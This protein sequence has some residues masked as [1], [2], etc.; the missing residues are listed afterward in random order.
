MLTLSPLVL[1]QL[2]FGLAVV[3]IALLD[4]FGLASATDDASSR[5]LNRLLASW[6]AEKG[7]QQVVVIL[8]DDAYLQRNQTYWPLP[9]SEQSKLFKRL[10]AYKP[11]AVFIDLLYSHDHSRETPGQAPRMESQ[12]LANVLERYR[13]QGIPLFLANTGFSADTQGAVNAL[14]R[15][16]EV[17]EP[18]LV[19]WSGHGNQYPLAVPTAVGVLETPA[20]QL[21]REYCHHHAC[22]PLPADAIA[23]ARLPDMAVQWGLKQSPS[24][25]KVSDISE[26]SFPGLADQLLHAV[27]WKLG[28]QAQANCAYSLTLSASDL[29]A[30]DADD[31]A[32][33]KQLLT[34]KLVLVGARIAGTGDVTLSPLHGKIAG[35]YVH[36]MA[37]DNLINWGMGYYR[38]TQSLA[39]LGVPGTGSVDVLDVGELL[40]LALIASLKGR[41]ESPVLTTSQTGSRRRLLLQPL[42]AWGVVLALVLGLSAAL[43][44]WN[45]TPANVLGLLLLSLTLF[46]TRVQTLLEDKA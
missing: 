44:R 36:A 12:L 7:Q 3:L 4:P 21:Y 8:I 6:Y 45:F 37:L 9:Y 33:L 46:K 19:S 40:L 14:P 24:Q 42:A 17:S 39:E 32:L 26:C 34:G 13:H 28:S 23:A 38:S 2:L 43:W 29:E 1:R 11:G 20:L 35:V 18:A 25:A 41:L 22:A 15:F 31:Q 16:A 10:L 30:T 27:F 5:W